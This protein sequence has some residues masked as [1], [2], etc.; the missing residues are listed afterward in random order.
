V[1]T[2]P[3]NKPMPRIVKGLSRHANSLIIEWLTRVLA[4]ISTEVPT[5]KSPSLQRMSHNL[6]RFLGTP[7]NDPIPGTA[8]HRRAFCPIPNTHYDGSV[9]SSFRNSSNL[10]RSV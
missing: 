6:N 3:K 4:Q 9:G 8:H 10:E 1:P 5:L 2:I 7:L